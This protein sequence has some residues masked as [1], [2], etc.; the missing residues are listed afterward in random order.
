MLRAE[1]YAGSRHL[2]TWNNS[3]GGSTY[4]NHAD[5][6]GTERVRSNSSG[7]ACEWI[8]SLP[9]GDGLATSGNCSNPEPSPNHFTGKERDAESGLDE[10]AVRHYGSSPG[11][12]MQP[13]P[14]W[15]K[16]DRMVDPQRLNL[17]A[18]G[19]DNPLK[20]SDPTG[21]DV[22]LGNCPSN[23][24]VSMCEAAITNGLKKEDR[25]HVHFVEGNGKNGYKKGEIGITVDADYKSSSGNFRDLQQAANDHS[26]LAIAE[27]E[28]S[29]TVVN[30][31]YGVKV[32]G[33][34]QLESITEVAGQPI[35]MGQGLGGYTLSTA[36]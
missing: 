7:T 29:G 25:S 35:P 2:A 30:G 19:R 32:A 10:F 15:V 34:V 22:K 20:S 13:D 16:G 31:D 17:Y 14:I 1:V 3:G 26:A 9:F 12:F 18:Y 4:F 8:T 33:K 11:R 28:P 5:W 27:P 6:L 24:T 21:M 23:M 36:G